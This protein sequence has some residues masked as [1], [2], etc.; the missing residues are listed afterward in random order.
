MARLSIPDEKLEY[1]AER[2]LLR[3]AE[4]YPGVETFPTPIE[5][6]CEGLFK[7]N[8]EPISFAET[9]QADKTISALCRQP[10]GRDVVYID[11]SIDPYEHP[12]LE[13][14][15]RFSI[16]HEIGHYLFHYEELIAQR[17]G[18]NLFD[19]SR[20]PLLLARS[21][22][23]DAIEEEADRFAAF[24]L[25]P[26]TRVLEVWARTFGDAHGPKDVSEE[27][28]A[29][30]A[31]PTFLYT[32]VCHLAHQLAKGFK[33]SGEAMQRRLTDLGLLLLEP[34]PQLSLL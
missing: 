19:Y 11:T 12:E 3:Y 23:K 26:K 27:I 4:K 21:N 2:T 7:I 32:P 30:K 1:T 20:T 17:E 28:A 15:Y 25:M 31:D 5:E 29:I 10:N 8:I 14:R 18:E 16:A 13:G 33:V 9:Y 24:L 34:D 6:I 22:H